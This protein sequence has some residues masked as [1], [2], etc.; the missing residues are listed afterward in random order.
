MLFNSFI[1]L[2]FL[3]LVW[4][5]DR[6]LPGRWRTH[7]LLVAS[8]A[9]YGYWHW[10][11]CSLLAVSTVV[12]FF[13]GQRLGAPE[14]S[15]S[16]RRYLLALSVCV[17]L[18][19]LGLFKY[20][21]FFASSLET[22]LGT[23]GLEADLFHLHVL[24][25]VGISFYTFQTMSYTIDIFRGAMQP[26]RSFASFALYVAFFPQLV[27]GPIERARRLLPQLEHRG[28]ATRTQLQSGLALITIGMFRKVVIGDLCGRYADHMFAGPEY[29]ASLELLVGLCLF[30][31]QIYNDF[32]GYS[33]IARGSARLLGVELMENFRQPY[34]ATSITDFWRRWHISLSTWLRDYLYISLGGNRR[35]RRRTY[36]NLMITMLLGGLWHGASWTFVVWGGLHGL[37][38][39]VHKFWEWGR[40][41]RL[42]APQRIVGTVVGWGATQ[43][44]V[45]LAWLFFR[46]ADFGTASYVL[47][48]MAEGTA[49]DFAPRLLS[50]LLSYCAMS[51]ALDWLEVGKGSHAWLVALRPARAVALGCIMWFAALGFLYLAEPHPFIYFQF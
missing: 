23:F 12:D 50:I 22:M 39:A 1:F 9:F 2:L 29:Y 48:K 16:R 10:G 27:A 3:A 21:D 25:P 38:L 17:N 13:V 30:S 40:D 7:F 32:A 34:F 14:V 41:D 31:L 47:N 20:F 51:A 28:Y 26:T 6:V 33:S 44:L 43:A 36:A 19:I 11:F 45:L 8:Y 5:V 35:G 49:G 42:K 46:A 24:L 15:L 37:Y 18:G 4:L